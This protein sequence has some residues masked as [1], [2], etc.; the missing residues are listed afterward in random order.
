M[1]KKHDKIKWLVAATNLVVLAAIAN[2]LFIPLLSPTGEIETAQ[3]RPVF[4]WGGISGAF[5]VMI[6]DNPSFSSPIFETTNDNRFQPDEPLS[7]GTHYWKVVSDNG[8]ES[9]TGMVTIVSEVSV[10]R[11]QGWLKNSGNT[12]IILDTSPGG[13]GLTGMMVGI[14]QTIDIKDD[15]NVFAKQA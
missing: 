11:G 5:T 10:K 14:N 9:A 6:D 2:F 1:H 7:F 12:D 15:D 13:F 3:R 8:V 4:S